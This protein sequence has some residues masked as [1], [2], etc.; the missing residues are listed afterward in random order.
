[1][2]NAAPG[3]IRLCE[4]SGLAVAGLACA[5]GFRVAMTPAAGYGVHPC[6]DSVPGKVV[7]AMRGA[8]IGSGWIPAGWRQFDTH[9]MAGIT[10]AR[11]VAHAADFP[12]LIGHQ[13]MAIR[14][15]RCMDKSSEGKILI[16]FIV[17]VQTKSQVLSFF[18]D[19]LDGERWPFFSGACQKYSSQNKHQPYLQSCMSG[20]MFSQRCPCTVQTE[21]SPVSRHILKRP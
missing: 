7:A 4:M 9:P 10:V 20:H 14:K 11:L 15:K 6:I 21:M 13:S 19:M 5:G 17:A 2:N 3:P 1:M 8:T 16:G 12:A 18:L